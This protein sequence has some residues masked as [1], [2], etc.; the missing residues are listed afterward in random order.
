MAAT[1]LLECLQ[2]VYRFFDALDIHAHD[3]ALAQF[4]K[5]GVWERQGRA[6]AGHAEIGA[7]LAARSPQRRTFHAVCNPVVSLDGENQATVRFFLMAYEAQLDQE[8]SAPLTP[9][10]IRRCVDRLIHDGH[11]WCIA[12]KSSWA[13]LPPANH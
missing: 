3:C 1:E 10:G 13:H 9:V 5:E 12:H 2:V 8:A 4:A 7:A 6:L 11:A